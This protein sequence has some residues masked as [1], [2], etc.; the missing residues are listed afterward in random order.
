VLKRYENGLERCIGCSL[1]AA[2][3]PTDCIY[4]EAAE[5]TDEDRRSPGERYAKTYEINMLRCIFCGYCAEACPT[6]A[7]VLEH[8]FALAEYNRW[9]AIYTKE[10]LLQPHDPPTSSSAVMRFL[11]TRRRGAG[12]RS[13]NLMLIA[14]TR[15]QTQFGNELTEIYATLGRLICLNKC[16]FFLAAVAVGAALGVVFN[17]NLVH[18]ALCLLLNFGVLAVFYVMLNAQFLGIVQVLV[19]AGDCGAVSFCGHV[20]GGRIGEKVVTWLIAQHY[21]CRVEPCSAYVCAARLFLKIL[22]KGPKAT[23]PRSGP[24]IWAGGVDRLG[25]F[26][27]YGLIVPDGG[28]AAVGGSDRRGLAGAALRG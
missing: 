28:R 18:S 24:A 15:S 8:D 21:F 5:N 9:D 27:D 14:S 26:T 11:L 4:V 22:F 17:K 7:I 25:F 20:V 16:S 6:E 3:C 13:G 2:A 1:C 23:L 12:R 10:Q 19:Y